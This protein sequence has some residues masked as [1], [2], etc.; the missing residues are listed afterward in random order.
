MSTQAEAL[1]SKRKYVQSLTRS[2]M[3][4]DLLLD[5]YDFP[6]QRDE[7]THEQSTDNTSALRFHFL[8]ILPAT[9]DSAVYDQ[10]FESIKRHFPR[11]SHDNTRC[12]QKRSRI[13]TT[14][15]Y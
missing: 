2:A 8:F 5:K 6:E 13:S 4:Q 7:H 9:T 15:Y 12:K 10:I 3:L 1:E 14:S 11:V